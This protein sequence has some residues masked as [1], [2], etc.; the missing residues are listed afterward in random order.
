MER[1]MTILA[2]VAW[3]VVTALV[4]ILAIFIIQPRQGQYRTVVREAL[5]TARSLTLYRLA[6]K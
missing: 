3:C 2:A 5:D 1:N 4:I 6:S